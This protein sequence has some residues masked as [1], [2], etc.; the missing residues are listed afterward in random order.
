MEFI[1]HEGIY[2]VVG[3]QFRPLVIQILWDY[4]YGYSDCENI[5]PSHNEG[6]SPGA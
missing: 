1:L 6:F 3:W 2:V 4:N 5:E